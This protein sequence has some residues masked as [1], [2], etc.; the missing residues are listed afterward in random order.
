MYI[1]YILHKLNL[2]STVQNA[3]NLQVIALPLGDN[4]HDRCV[5]TP[6]RP[7]ETRVVN[8]ESAF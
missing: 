8:E 2:L 3:S 7:T 4:I 6:T 1:Q 5:P